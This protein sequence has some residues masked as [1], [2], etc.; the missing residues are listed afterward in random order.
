M[1]GS[2]F[3]AWLMITALVAAAATAG[4]D[5]YLHQA[6]PASAPTVVRAP[7][8][9][10]DLARATEPLRRE[11]EAAK[12]ALAA[13]AADRDNLKQ[14]LDALNK[15]APAAAGDKAKDRAKDGAKDKDKDKAAAAMQKQ[16]EA[17]QRQRDAA[18]SEAAA[19]KRRTQQLEAQPRPAPSPLA[20]AAAV[21]AGGKV[22]TQ[23][24]VA[25]LREL[26][27]GGEAAPGTPPAADETG[28]W[29]ETTS[30]RVVGIAG[31][32]VLLLKK[33]NNNIQCAFAEAA[34]AKLATLRVGD[35]VRV[36]GKINSEQ[37]GQLV[38]LEE[39][40]FKE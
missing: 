22:Y 25:E 19:S 7:P 4:Y 33:D 5:I 14:Q 13:I 23:H 17:A 37:K 20:P 40:E 38:N 32:G 31:G 3:R 18:L 26:Y 16:L 10:A 30:M 15:P 12:L 11:L 2:S 34:K 8:S 35:A 29:I 27:A 39:C 21:P 24:S 6:A 9:A 1:P 28:K 36:S